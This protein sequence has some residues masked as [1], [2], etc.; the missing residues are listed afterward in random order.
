MIKNGIPESNIIVLSYD[1]VPSADENPFKGKLFNK[2]NG[3]DVYEG[4]KIDYRKDDVTPQNFLNILKGNTK[5]LKGGNGRVLKTNS[6]SKIFV[7]F[8]D[9]GAPGYIAFPNDDLYANVLIETLSY[10]HNHTL[11]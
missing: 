4:C 11:Y 9:H 6:K 3:T 1:D 2:P 10:M 5:A 8:T 7:Y